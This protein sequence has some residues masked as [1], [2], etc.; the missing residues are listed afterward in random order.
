MKLSLGYITAPTKKEAKEI[1]LALLEDELIA[2]ANIFDK[3]ESYFW[4][5]DGIAQEKEVV[6]IIKTRAKNEKAITRLVRKMHSCECP[7]VVFTSLD[8]GNPEFL[9]W[10]DENC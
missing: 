2:C 8:Y 10:V 5:Q 7:C 1:V 6:I 9:K 4:W 3:V